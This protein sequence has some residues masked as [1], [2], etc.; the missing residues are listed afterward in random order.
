MRKLLLFLWS[1]LPIGAGAYHFGP[2]QDRMRV[3]EAG[4][5]LDRAEAL[6]LEARELA[7]IQGDEAAR[8]LWLAVE[9][10]Y[11]EA[12]DALPADN[13]D[14]A[15]RLRLERAKAQMF[16]SRLPEA[17]RDLA[18]L[19]DELA[20]DASVDPALLADARGALANAQYYTTW[21]K[22]LEGA[23]QA[24]WEPEIE[25]SRQNYK[26]LAEELDRRGE[27]KLAALA[28]EDLESSIRLARMDLS[29]LQGL[30]LPS[31]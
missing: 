10:A 4:V 15:R 7:S 24:E 14:E 30:P 2:G 16:V 22:R 3:D 8:D 23:P 21:L 17:R 31:Q 13:V 20:A 18:G 19:V 11:G 28:K 6:A 25:A 26:L 1:L 27:S 29:D 12:L 9:A 5:A